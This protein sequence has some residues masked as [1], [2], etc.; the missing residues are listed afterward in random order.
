[1][2]RS[3]KKKSP[4]TVNTYKIVHWVLF[5]LLLV[6]LIVIFFFERDRQPRTVVET[7]HTVSNHVYIVTNY[8]PLAGVAADP[9]LSSVFPTNS[10]GGRIV[11]DP[12]YEIP[13]SYQ[14]FTQGYRKFV[15][16]G[17]FNFTIGDDTSY[18][19]IASIF[20]ERV[21]LDNGY[22]L[23]NQDFDERFGYGSSSLNFQ[24]QFEPKVFSN[25]VVRVP[26]VPNTRGNYFAGMATEFRLT[27]KTNATRRVRK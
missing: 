1:M 27:S 6:N 17:G 3:V 18:G 21:L 14:F 22:S 9:K 8:F 19:R 20:P 12:S 2:T 26:Q 4:V 24:K 10:L 13:L 7:I 23:K 5:L 16:I 11:N 15:K 25:G